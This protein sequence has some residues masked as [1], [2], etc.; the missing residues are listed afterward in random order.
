[1]GERNQKRMQ[2]LIFDSFRE[3]MEN[4]AFSDITITDIADKALVHRNT[5][6]HHFTD[7][8]DL[9]DKFIKYELENYE[10]NFNNFKNQPFQ[11]I[12]DLYYSSIEKVINQQKDD[13]TFETIAQNSFL[14]LIINAQNDERIFWH[15]GKIASILLWNDLNENKYDLFRDYKLL[16]EI[17]HTEKFPENNE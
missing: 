15:I 4:N 12:H 3:L 8:Y 9:L 13:H 5:I 2:K 7:K 11:M 1:M 16:D 14:K 17:Y 10:F 6:Y